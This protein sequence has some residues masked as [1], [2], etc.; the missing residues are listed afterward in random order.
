MWLLPLALYYL[1]ERSFVSA[2]LFTEGAT[3]T[4]EVVVVF[5]FYV[6]RTYV[7]VFAVVAQE[8]AFSSFHW[9]DSRSIEEDSFI[10][11]KE[12]VTNLVKRNPYIPDPKLNY[13]DTP[14]PDCGSKVEIEEPCRVVRYDNGLADES[15]IQVNRCVNRRG[16][17]DVG[18]PRCEW[19]EIK[20]IE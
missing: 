7:K 13:S 12:P 5:H 19:K 6:I 14:C 17:K 10:R 15:L 8:L 18:K 1:L 16:R 2:G 11:G 20:T 9:Q 4:L 3:P